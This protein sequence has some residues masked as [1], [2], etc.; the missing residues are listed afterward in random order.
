MHKRI[1]YTLKEISGSSGSWFQGQKQKTKAN[2][3]SGATENKTDFN[4]IC[5]RKTA[6]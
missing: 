1:N 2:H 4:Y 5:Y 6:L 3:I